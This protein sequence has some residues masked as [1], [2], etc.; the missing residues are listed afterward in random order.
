[1]LRLQTAEGPPPPRLIRRAMRPAVGVRGRL[2]P[3]LAAWC[4]QHHHLASAPDPGRIGLRPRW[5]TLMRADSGAGCRRLAGIPIPPCQ[6]PRAR[7]PV[8][9][10][11]VAARLI[12]PVPVPCPARLAASRAARRF[13]PRARRLITA[14]AAYAAPFD[15]QRT[16]RGAGRQ[17]PGP[18]W[19]RPASLCRDP[20]PDRPMSQ[21]GRVLP[22]GMP[23]RS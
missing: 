9:D 23:C 8:P 15:L 21:P 4:A 7:S 20:G 19:Y 12:L 10:P 11:A 18:S 5:P 14:G 2:R 1:M 17:R 6:I 3:R 22:K 16:L 13:A